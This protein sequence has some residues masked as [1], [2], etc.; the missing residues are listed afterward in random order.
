[1]DTQTKKYLYVAMRDRA[2]TGTRLAVGSPVVQTANDTYGHWQTPLS[3][4]GGFI[5]LK[6][7]ERVRTDGVMDNY[8][9]NADVDHAQWQEGTYIV[10]ARPHYTQAWTLEEVG[11]EQYHIRST[12]SQFSDPALQPPLYMKV[13]KDLSF[14]PNDGWVYW[15]RTSRKENASTWVFSPA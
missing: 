15:V 2:I 5:W 13:D 10:I 11:N 4:K 9:T 3:P 1:M 7:K 8:G 12:L 14:D 6:N